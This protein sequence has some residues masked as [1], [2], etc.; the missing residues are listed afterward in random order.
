VKYGHAQVRRDTIVHRLRAAGYLG[1]SEIARD[2]GVSE[3]TVR[4]DLRKLGA[5]QAVNQVHGGAS[6]PMARFAASYSARSEVNV[7]AKNAIAARAAA[8]I[9]R[10]DA[11]AIDAGTTTMRLVHHLP[12]DFEGSVIT[13][14]MPVIDHMMR[15]GEGRVVT[16]GGEL[17]R[18]SQAF[19]GQMAVDACQGLRVRYCFLGAA[20]MD[21]R[22]IYVDAD[23]ERPTKLALIAAAER[24]VLL[25]DHTKHAR[26]A[27]VLLCRPA[28]I[29]LLIT[30]APPPAAYA[31]SLRRAG[32]E[33]LVVPAQR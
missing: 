4:R 27:P 22:G 23:I 3:M 21:A 29:H 12:G 31:R 14:S 32:A 1:V 15:R 20:A 24:V 30:D 26:S 16:L 17:H 25:A 10:T 6:L 33:I 13:P 11:V 2:L 19:A 9:G 5:D 8:L 28:C 18:P 7:A